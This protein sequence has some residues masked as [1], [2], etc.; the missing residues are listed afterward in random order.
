MPSAV[1]VNIFGTCLAVPGILMLLFYKSDYM[2]ESSGLRFKRVIRYFPA[3][4]KAEILN[5]LRE[6][7]S[8]GNWKTSESASGLMLDI[9]VGRNDDNVYVRVS[10]FVP[11]NYVPCSE[12]FTYDKAQVSGL[13]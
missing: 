9:Y 5:W 6:N 7:P 12:W 11:Y 3:S 13:L 2:D 8:A 4:K 1:S 10:E